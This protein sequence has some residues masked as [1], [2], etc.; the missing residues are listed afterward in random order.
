[1]GF[2]TSAVGFQTSAMAYPDQLPSEDEVV[3]LCLPLEAHLDGIRYRQNLW[4]KFGKHVSKDEAYA[5]MYAF[6]HAD[7]AVVS[8]PKIYYWFERDGRT[9]ILMEF[10]DCE[11]LPQHL[12]N[13]PSER[14]KWDNAIVA[15]V[16]HLWSF[17]VHEDAKPGPLAR[18][19]P[20]GPFFAEH[21][22]NRTFESQEE[23]ERWI[24]GKL[25]RNR[26]PERVE[27]GSQPLVFSHGDLTR[28][29]FIVKNGKL[30]LLNFG[31]SGFY[32]KCFEEVALFHCGDWY[33][34]IRS[35]LFGSRSANLPGMVWARRFNIMD[36]D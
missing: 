1:M 26:R 24:N 5:Q 33:K 6:K 14:D 16:E 8:V 22:V 4:I 11:T 25:Q 32:P 29:Q 23:L 9:Y 35:R 19:I 31:A 34:K 12:K 2:Q 20:T 7:P 10:I 36:R 17:P 3:E 27:F 30:Y 28:R 21:D 18:G 13:N 15:A